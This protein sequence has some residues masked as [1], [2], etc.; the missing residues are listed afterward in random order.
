MVNKIFYLSKKTQKFY[1]SYLETLFFCKT[2]PPKL[3]NG[4][5]KRDRVSYYNGQGYLGTMEYTCLPAFNL[6]GNKIV[7]CQNGIWSPMPQCICMNLLIL[8]FFS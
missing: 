4:L 5:I 7:T 2:S 8:E 3:I 1:S 6:D